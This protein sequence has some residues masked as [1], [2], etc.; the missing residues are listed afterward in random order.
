MILDIVTYGH[1]V[2][3]TRGRKITA[4]GERLYTLAADMIE[5]MYANELVGMA[6]HQVGKAVQMFV[7]GVPQDEK[8][9]S[10]M[11]MAGKQ[12]P[13]EEHMPLVVINPKIATEGE[14]QIGIEGS[15]CLPGVYGE[16]KRPLG[17]SLH[18]QDLDNKPIEL[19]AQGLLARAIQH[20]MDHLQAILFFDRM[21]DQARRKLGSSIYEQ[22]TNFSSPLHGDKIRSD[23]WS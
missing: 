8:Q 22:I 7:L 3:R 6:A 5:T 15:P 12:A 2:L 1:P 19:R 21:D 9:P 23:R 20:E 18:A 11:W 14:M 10:Q 4:L 17:V 16:V 13:L